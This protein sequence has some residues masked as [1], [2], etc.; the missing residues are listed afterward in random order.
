MSN[1]SGDFHHKLTCFCFILH[2][3]DESIDSNPP[4]IR[5]KDKMI[6]YKFNVWNTC[7]HQSERWG[8]IV[9]AIYML[10]DSYSITA[11]QKSCLALASSFSK[12]SYVIMICSIMRGWPPHL[13]LNSS[14][15]Q[16][17]DFWIYKQ[18]FL[19]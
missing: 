3:W 12:L 4:P 16:A 10:S 17:K 19:Q 13:Y 5:E 14:H 6:D 2:V 1:L 7:I 15:I 8:P 18:T 11:Q 9:I